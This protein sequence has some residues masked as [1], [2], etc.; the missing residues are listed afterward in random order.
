MRDSTPTSGSFS[1]IDWG[2]DSHFLSVELDETGG[3]SY[4]ALGLA[5]SAMN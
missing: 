3:S 2:S 4:T 5:A 1:A